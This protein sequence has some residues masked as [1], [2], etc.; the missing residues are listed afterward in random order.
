LH[1][2]MFFSNTTLSSKRVCLLLA[3]LTFGLTP[4]QF[5]HADEAPDSD[6]AAYGSALSDLA[7]G[8]TQAAIEGFSTIVARNPNHQGALLDLA[9]AYCHPR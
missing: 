9:L 4:L 3:A 8:R 6:N 7:A 5:A 1:F 2:L